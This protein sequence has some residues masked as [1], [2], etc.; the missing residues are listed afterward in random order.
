MSNNDISDFGPL[1]NFKKLKVIDL[2]FNKINNINVLENIS[3]TNNKIEKLYLN[4]NMI[5]NVEI[6]KKNIFPNI[7]EINLDK[8]NVIKKDLK[9]IK[10]I[11]Q[12]NNN[13]SNYRNKY[14]E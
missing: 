2:S 6:L 5:K 11:I 13:I 7:I 8:N 3:K 10:M 4:G 12:N 14:I 9:E 1:K